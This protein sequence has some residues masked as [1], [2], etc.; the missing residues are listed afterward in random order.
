MWQ[1]D[2]VMDKSTRRLVAAEKDQEL[3]NVFEN[4]KSTRK[5]VASGISDID[6]NGTMWPHNLHFSIAYVSH[7]G[8]V[9]SNVR[10]R[11]GRKLGDK[12]EDLDVNTIL[13]KMY[14]S[15][16]LQAAVHLGTIM[17]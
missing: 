13:W 7:P 1:K 14:M 16:I 8:K 9:L 4:L 2:A 15:V 11:F 12:M 17:Q 10:Q 5:L 6:G 3:Q